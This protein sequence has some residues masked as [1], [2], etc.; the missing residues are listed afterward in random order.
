MTRSLS[1]G[2][3]MALVL[4]TA[5]A[6]SSGD[7]GSAPATTPM[8][9]TGSTQSAAGT[10]STGGGGAA[11]TST[12]GTA[13]G[14]AGAAS[15]AGTTSGGQSTTGG[16]GTGG[17]TTGGAATGG[18]GGSGGVASMP[19]NFTCTMYLGLLTTNEWY[20][21]GY[22]MDGVDGTKWELKYHHFGYVRTWA[23]ATSPFWGETGDSF[24]LDQGSSIQ[25]PCAMNPMQPDRIVFAALDWEMES[26]AEWE[27]ALESFLVTVKAKYPSVKW[28]D[29][30]TLIRCPM[31]KMCN[32]NADYGPGANPVA[33][34][35]DCYIPPFEDAAIAAV[36]AKHADWVG[37]GP[38]VEANAC[39]SPVD[40]AHLSAD[41]NKQAAKDVAAYYTLH[42]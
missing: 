31:N 12:A 36:A 41:T 9:G 26:Q 27:T 14:G 40:G 11:S 5:G 33:G 38:K 10:T 22:E 34:R 20:S 4:G 42:P 17:A 29:L 15:V 1:L 6:C 32:P 18:S 19:M 16:G 28:L 24:A 21:Q 3:A 2:C 37:V 7:P 30:M 35:Q 39:R 8:A 23:D 13:S 25:S